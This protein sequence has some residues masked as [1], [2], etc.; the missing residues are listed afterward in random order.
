MNKELLE[1]AFK[2]AFH[3]NEPEEIYDGAPT[4]SKYNY[5]HWLK[6]FLEQV[7]ELEQIEKIKDKS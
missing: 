1:Q 4:V 7:S 3:I 6:R 5:H 2:K